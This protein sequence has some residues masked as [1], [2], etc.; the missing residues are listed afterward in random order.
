[1][2]HIEEGSFLK[3]V[4]K[5]RHSDVAF[6]ASIERIH[7]LECFELALECEV[8]LLSPE[9][10]LTPSGGVIDIFGIVFVGVFHD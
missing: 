9:H 7:A 5:V 2:E 8:V 6:F 10:L 4:E 3:Y 1:M